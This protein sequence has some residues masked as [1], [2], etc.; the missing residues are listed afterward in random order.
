M[1]SVVIQSSKWIS[2]TEGIKPLCF[3]TTNAKT[4]N[5][6]HQTTREFLNKG[7]NVGALCMN[8]VVDFINCVDR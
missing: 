1:F 2:I 6:S 4:Y 3:E 8:V 7:I 5:I